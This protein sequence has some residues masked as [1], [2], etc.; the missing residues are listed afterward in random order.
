MKSVLADQWF[1]LTFRLFDTPLGWGQSL[2]QF[3]WSDGLPVPSVQPWGRLLNLPPQ[4]VSPRR[5]WK[6]IPYYRYQCRR[7]STG[8][9]LLPDGEGHGHPAGHSGGRRQPDHCVRMIWGIRFWR[10]LESS[11]ESCRKRI[12]K[13]FRREKSPW[14]CYRR[15]WGG[16]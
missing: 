14:F 16:L 6:K 13:I 3:R 2:L 8:Q 15:L 1:H 5:T 12:S 7:V 10:L 4:I 11:T 9:D